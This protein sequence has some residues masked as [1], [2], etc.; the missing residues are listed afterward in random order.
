M[1]TTPSSIAVEV[2]SPYTGFHQKI[3]SLYQHN[4]ENSILEPVHPALPCPLVKIISYQPVSYD[5]TSV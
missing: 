4:Y 5:I 1:F 3:S 2:P